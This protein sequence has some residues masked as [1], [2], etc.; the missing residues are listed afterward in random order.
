MEW[1]KVWQPLDP[2]KKQIRVL[3]L[4]PNTNSFESPTVRLE[5]AS[6][7]ESPEYDAIS[8]AWGGA[9]D[10]RP[11]YVNGVRR[12]ITESLETCFRR[13]RH[14]AFERRLW[15]DTL[16]INQYDNKGKGRQ[17][18]IMQD[19]FACAGAVR[20]WLGARVP[21]MW[22]VMNIIGK[23]SQGVDL[24]FMK[25]DGEPLS[26]YNQDKIAVFCSDLWWERLWVVQEFALARRVYFHHDRESI[27]FEQL[28]Y[29]W[30][31]MRE[32]DRLWRSTGLIPRSKGPTAASIPR[33][34]SKM[35]HLKNLH[36]GFRPTP[37]GELE[38]PPSE[39]LAKL[40]QVLA[41]I[42]QLPVT[43]VVDHLIGL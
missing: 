13:F 10:M 29:F 31:Q 38:I 11:V 28:S 14:P 5:V 39:R 36:V 4:E 27:S 35:A 24:S 16:C 43:S 2:C 21:L 15:C 20:I 40:L 42:K 32:K 30:A 26:P 34:S 41:S 23:A 19:I 22:E 7:E 18:Q 17:I 33:M 8:Y 3:V 37:D 6:L 1:R 9:G 12:N 25:I